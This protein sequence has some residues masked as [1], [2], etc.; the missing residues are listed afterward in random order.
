MGF[1]DLGTSGNGRAWRRAF[2]RCFLDRRPPDTCSVV[3]VSEESRSTR[4]VPAFVKRTVTVCVQVLV[5]SF[6]ALA[7]R[8]QREEISHLDTN[9]RRDL[10]DPGGDG[11]GLLRGVGHVLAAW[12]KDLL[13]SVV[14]KL[15]RGEAG[16]DRDGNHLVIDLTAMGG[17]GG[18][19]APHALGAAQLVQEECGH[20]SSTQLHAVVTGHPMDTFSEMSDRQKRNQAATFQDMCAILAG[21]AC[22]PGF[23]SKGL[24]VAE[25]FRMASNL[26]C[27]HDP[28]DRG[29]TQGSFDATVGGLEYFLFE[30]QVVSPVF[31]Q[32]LPDARRDRTNDGLA[33]VGSAG[34]YRLYCPDPERQLVY[35]H[36][37]MAAL[38]AEAQQPVR[39]IQTMAAKMIKQYGL[40]EDGKGEGLNK[41]IR[42]AAFGVEDPMGARIRS[43]PRRALRLSSKVDA[44]GQH[45]EECRRG[46]APLRKRHRQ[47]AETVKGQMRM[48]MDEVISGSLAHFNVATTL[49]FVRAM[50]EIGQE[51]AR[52][53]EEATARLVDQNEQVRQQMARLRAEAAARRG[54][55]ECALHPF[56]KVPIPAAMV[57]LGELLLAIEN[58][59]EIFKVCAEVQAHFLALLPECERVLVGMLETLQVLENS[60]GELVSE[61]QESGMAHRGLG[62]CLDDPEEFAEDFG[63]LGISAAQWKVAAQRLRALFASS[64]AQKRRGPSAEEVQRLLESEAESA[65]RLPESDVTD[66]LEARLDLG[67]VLHK[68][69]VSASPLIVLDPTYKLANQLCYVLLP[70][71]SGSSLVPRIRETALAAGLSEDPVFLASPSSNEIVFLRVVVRIPA[72][73]VVSIQ[74][75]EKV[76]RESSVEDQRR[77]HR[78]PI[79]HLLPFVSE[80]PS[81]TEAMRFCVMGM[82]AGMVD[83]SDGEWNFTSKHGTRLSLDSLSPDSVSRVFEVYRTAVEA[84]TWFVAETLDKKFGWALQRLRDVALLPELSKGEFPKVMQQLAGELKELASLHHQKV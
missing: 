5:C 18:S 70:S 64:Y 24:G 62:L 35:H 32:A 79:L 13:L 71:G 41:H 48:R 14:S 29:L 19:A 49:G 15:F 74:R 61:V 57:Q 25:P 51:K 50:R 83:K 10:A 77:A 33:T 56:R 73:A 69:F 60:C 3:M 28:G 23:S 46:L 44:I 6:P 36:L 20:A 65:I 43:K 80:R 11:M 66:R 9:D 76:Y 27:L 82:A 54:L 67:Q 42:Q 78:M 75:A 37:F 81:A 63:R 58:D 4:T 40:A 53:L 12:N 26:W 38:Y 8:M 84:S 22:H 39:N 68:A 52:Q 17:T 34:M 21:G 47:A 16:R 72:W 45:I 1:L 7:A 59:I 2:Q 30:H 55:K 31:A